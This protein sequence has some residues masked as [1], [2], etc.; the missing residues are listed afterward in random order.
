MKTFYFLLLLLAPWVGFAASE[1]T[2]VDEPE[3]ETNKPGVAILKSVGMAS[4]FK[5][6]KRVFVRKGVK[7]AAI[8]TTTE[9]IGDIPPVTRKYVQFYVDADNWIEINLADPR[10]FYS[11]FVTEVTISA[12][13]DSITVTVP[14]KQYCEVFFKSTGKFLDGNLRES[15]AAG[16]LQRGGHI[17]P[18]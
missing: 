3:K 15:V 17:L 16:Y 18:R 1:L 9:S 14:K 13:D 2:I 6:S 4:K 5:I 8:I 7:V 11:R 12:S 10:I